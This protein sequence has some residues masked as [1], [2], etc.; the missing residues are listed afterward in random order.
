M[1]ISR[2]ADIKEIEHGLKSSDPTERMLAKNAG[3]KIKK[4]DAWTKGARE[5]LVEETRR[6]NKGNARQIREDMIDHRGGRQGRENRGEKVSFS[7]HFP[8][9]FFK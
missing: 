7:F 6:G 1:D 4:E 3:E 8:D 5:R 9:G 2:K